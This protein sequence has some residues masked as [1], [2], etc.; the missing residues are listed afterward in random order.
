MH[1]PIFMM[2]VLRFDNDL[3]KNLP[4]FLVQQGKKRMTKIKEH[5]H[6]LKAITTP[7]DANKRK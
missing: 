5:D 1:T 2:Q 6:H 3:I 4:H 7:N